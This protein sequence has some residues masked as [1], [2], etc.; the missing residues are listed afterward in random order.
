MARPAFKVTAALI[1]R[2]EKLA[3][4]GLT[5][6]QIAMSIGWGPATLMRKKRANKALYDAIETGRAAGI[7]EVS[8]KLY[9]KAMTGDNTAMIFYLKNRDPA[10]WEEVQKRIHTGKDGG[11]IKSEFKVKFD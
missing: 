9:E 8:N 10:N 1:R 3:S 2:C 5:N 11:D 7:E 6:T 4:R